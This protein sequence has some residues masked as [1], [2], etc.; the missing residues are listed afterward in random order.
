[1]EDLSYYSTIIALI[2]IQISFCWLFWD[3]DNYWKR[4]A[5][6]RSKLDCR[7]VLVIVPNVDQ[8]I[9]AKLREELRNVGCAI[10]EVNFGPDLNQISVCSDVIPTE[11]TELVGEAV[12]QVRKYEKAHSR[13]RENA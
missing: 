12:R 1:M 4:M 10:Y 6:N 2:S 5:K 8:V 3:D 13:G 11:Q 9:G 7:S